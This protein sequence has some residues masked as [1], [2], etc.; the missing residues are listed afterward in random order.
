M[1]IWYIVLLS[2]ASFLIQSHLLPLTGIIKGFLSF[3]E[4]TPPLAKQHLLRYWAWNRF[5]CFC[6]TCV[7]THKQMFEK[8]TNSYIGIEYIYHNLWKKVWNW[9]CWFIKFDVINH[10]KLF[11]SQFTLA[12]FERGQTLQISMVTV[13]LT[14]DCEWK[15]WFK[16]HPNICPIIPRIQLLYSSCQ[17]GTFNSFIFYLLLIS[18]LCVSSRA[19]FYILHSTFY[20]ATFYI[21]QCWFVDTSVQWSQLFLIQCR[22]SLQTYCCAAQGLRTSAQEPAPENGTP[23]CRIFYCT[24]HFNFFTIISLI[25]HKEKIGNEKDIRELAYEK[26]V[27]KNQGNNE[28]RWTV[29][30]AAVG[31]WFRNHHLTFK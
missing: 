12:L 11:C 9:F 28:S 14:Q 8:S 31:G 27:R 16:T 26:F 7:D 10:A 15:I 2:V 13:G 23:G 24:F 22:G 5:T 21:L 4:K 25:G 29:S 3:I 1:H 19:T 20:I 17:Q 30:R 6:C 18:I